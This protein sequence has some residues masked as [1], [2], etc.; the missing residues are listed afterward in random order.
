MCPWPPHQEMEYNSPSFSSVLPMV[1]LLYPIKWDRSNA[2]GFLRLDQKYDCFLGFL[3]PHFLGALRLFLLWNQHPVFPFDLDKHGCFHVLC[4]RVWF[5]FE[6]L[7]NFLRLVWLLGLDEIPQARLNPVWTLIFVSL[8]HTWGW[9]EN[10]R[11]CD[12]G[13]V[14]ELCGWVQFLRASSMTNALLLTYAIFFYGIM[15]ECCWHADLG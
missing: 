4:L 3:E 9:P 13:V 14:Q 8:L 11:I 1:T 10:Q 7:W 6:M 12:Y 2:I 15:S 5:H